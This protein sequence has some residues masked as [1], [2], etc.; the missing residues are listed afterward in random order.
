MSVSDQQLVNQTHHPAIY[1]LSRAELEDLRKRLRGM[2]DHERTLARQ[3]VREPR[4]KAPPRGRGFPGT[5]EQP[6]RRKQ[7]YAGALKRVNGEV[8]R[9]RK[10][11]A[12]H[13][14]TDSAQR[15]LAMRKAGPEF[16]RPENTPTA[17]KGP[18]SIPSTRN[19][20]ILPGSKVGSVSQANKNAQARR[21]GRDG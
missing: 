16:N 17:N 4:G 10:I 2:R 6:T 19:R 7:V 3:K 15:A 18:R 9:L 11:E 20:E 12:R 21:D 5:I 14:L 1:Q 8:S 13:A